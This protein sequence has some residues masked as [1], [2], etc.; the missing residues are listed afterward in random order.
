M[1]PIAISAIA[2]CLILAGTIGGAMLR[3]RL[4]EP[5]LTGDSKEVIRLATALVGTLTAV[6]LALLFAATRTSFEHTSGYVSRLAADIT[7]L[8]ETLEDYGPEAIPIRKQLRAEIGPLIDSIWQEEA[9]RAGRRIHLKSARGASATYLLRQLQ[10]QNPQ[11]EALQARALA[12]SSDIAQTRLALF[13]Q[14]PD[15]VSHPF[16]VVLVLWLTFIFTTFSMSAK[17]NA[18]L[19]IVLGVCVLSAS[20]AVYLILEL[21][22]PFDGLMQVS[23]DTLREALRPI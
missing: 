6:V 18:T 8:D 13:A 20:A 7:E 15:S 12:I 9:A 16:I 23:N 1:S 17:P 14:P 10:P 3:A 4:P 5:H 19:T 22:L 2:F 11:Q 21:G